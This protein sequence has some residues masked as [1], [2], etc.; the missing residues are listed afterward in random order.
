MQ[1][2]PPVCRGT[3]AIY[4]DAESPVAVGKYSPALPMNPP[5]PVAA[6]MVKLG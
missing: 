3:Q 6:Y 4:S 1:S 2:C 5:T